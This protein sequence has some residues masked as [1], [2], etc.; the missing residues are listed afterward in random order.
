MKERR[1]FT[2][3]EHFLVSGQRTEMRVLHFWQQCYSDLRDSG[4]RLAEFLVLKAL[5]ASGSERLDYWKTYQI[6]YRGFDILIRMFSGLEADGRAFVHDKNRCI[7]ISNRNVDLYIVCHCGA[8]TRAEVLDL[9]KWKFYILPIWLIN[10][11]CGKGN[12]MRISRLRRLIKPV[13]YLNIKEIVDRLIDDGGAERREY[14][15]EN[16]NTGNHK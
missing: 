14:Y 15:A 1:V 10:A 7:N 2:G 11:K 3:N 16:K 5:G 12:A 6:V 9:D 13:E 8:M 4:A